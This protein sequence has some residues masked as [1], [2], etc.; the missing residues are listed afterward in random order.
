MKAIVCDGF[1]GA[2]V[3]KVGDRPIP[4]PAEGEVLVKVIYSALN[5]ADIMQRKG[6]YPPPPGVTDVLGLECL[7]QIVEDPSKAG[8]DEEKLGSKV[9]ALIAGG[10]YAQYV[11]VRQE[12]TIAVPNNFPLDQAAAFMEVFC[13][14]YQ[15]LFLVSNA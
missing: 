12:H 13:T 6:S 1:G 14:A 11:K 2:E 7:G 8:T 5:R 15:I 4:K 10:G 9:I 3:L